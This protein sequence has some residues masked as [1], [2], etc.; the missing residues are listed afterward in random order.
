MRDS[1]EPLIPLN[2]CK[3][4]H[5]PANFQIFSRFFMSTTEYFYFSVLGVSN[6][7]YSSGDFSSFSAAFSCLSWFSPASMVPA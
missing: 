1:F 7:L 3:I 4:T 2:G 6:F 5:F